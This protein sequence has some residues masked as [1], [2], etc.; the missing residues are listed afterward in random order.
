MAMS[1]TE[2][3]EDRIVRTVA[4]YREI[5]AKQFTAEGSHNLF[6]GAFFERLMS[7]DAT[8][9]DVDAIVRM[10]REGHPSAD[11]ALRHF[12]DVT[13]NAHRFPH[14]P[15]CVQEY[16]R[17]CMSQAPLSV[18]YPS[19]APQVVNDLT[20][21]WGIC[22]CMERVKKTY[23]EIPLLHRTK[24]HRS[25]ADLVGQAFELK[26]DQTRR[27]Y[28]ADGEIFEKLTDFF[29][30]PQRQTFGAIPFA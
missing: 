30:L 27:I 3:V 8:L 24:Q 28:Q 20:R 22:Y 19:R 1:Y 21:N 18:G 12:I 26:E 14:L 13:M 25:A 10:A 15:L 9:D 29:V 6:E 5:K 7:P 2:A 17:K 23:P 11:R 16:A 4:K